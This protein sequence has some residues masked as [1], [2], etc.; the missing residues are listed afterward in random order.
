MSDLG[1]SYGLSVLVQRLLDKLVEIG[2]EDAL[3]VAVYIDGAQAVARS[4]VR[5]AL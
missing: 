1:M 4:S 3:Q 2:A 5:E